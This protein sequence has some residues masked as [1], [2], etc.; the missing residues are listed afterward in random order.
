[1][2]ICVE[3]LPFGVSEL[4]LAEFSFCTLSAAPLDLY[5]QPFRS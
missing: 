4:A 1:M 3:E 2:R 5:V